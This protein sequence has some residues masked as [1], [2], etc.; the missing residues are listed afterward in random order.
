MGESDKDDARGIGSSIRGTLGQGRRGGGAGSPPTPATKGK[1]CG[2]TSAIVASALLLS[3]LLVQRHILFAIRYHGSHADQNVG[4]PNLEKLSAVW[5]PDP[6]PAKSTTTTS[7]GE[8]VD[9]RRRPPPTIDRVNVLFALS[10]NATSFL[11]EF[12]VAL[13]SVGTPRISS[14]LERCCLFRTTFFVRRAIIYLHLLR[15]FPISTERCS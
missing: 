8:D 15:S 11:G 10:G 12:E 14:R 9:H 3:L 13:R 1:K 7:K 4:G 6:L 5:Y 2:R